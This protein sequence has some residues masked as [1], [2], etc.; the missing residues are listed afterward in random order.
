MF[1]AIFSAGEAQSAFDTS[2]LIQS[3]Q[4]SLPQSVKHILSS[5]TAK[6]AGA[7]LAT[8]GSYRLVQ[9]YLRS[10]AI[11]RLNEQVQP[12]QNLEHA[13]GVV[14]LF[15]HGLGGSNKCGYSYNDTGKIFS[16]GQL[17]SFDFQD[18]WLADPE[19]SSCLGQDADI[20]Q[21]KKY[22]NISVKGGSR[23]GT[24]NKVNI[25]GLSR[26]A[27][28]AINFLA[29][30]K[31]R[32]VACAVIESP[33]DDL[34]T[35]VQGK[36]KAF[37][38]GHI[39]IVGSILSAC[40]TPIVTMLPVGLQNHTVFGV[41]P[42]DV[43]S[44]IPKDIPLLFVSSKQD[45]LI[46][47]QSTQLLFDMLKASGHTKCHNIICNTGDHCEIVLNEANEKVREKIKEFM[48]N[49]QVFL[50]KQKS[51]TTVI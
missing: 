47:Q 6:V 40:I 11:N 43:V 48:T 49:P 35:I 36:L 33:F 9:K 8:Y 37:G 31:P 41:Y 23:I 18:S 12:E 14:T 2:R 19:L 24:D 27:A 26:G 50:D 5:K 34:E 28:T 1:V 7:T 30:H 44:N 29:I 20:N 17:V 39:P 38:I 32:N 51:D 13:K 22:Y 21:L 10:R 25:Y 45:G 4:N 46:P 3:I 16:D 15:A 42:K